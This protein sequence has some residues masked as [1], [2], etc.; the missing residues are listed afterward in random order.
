MKT[1]KAIIIIVLLSIISIIGIQTAT[2]QRT[3]AQ[4]INILSNVIAE[5]TAVTEGKEN[6]KLFVVNTIQKNLTA[7]IYILNNDSWIYI[8]RVNN[9]YEFCPIE[10]GDWS[11]NLNTEA[12]LY[13]I[14][15]TYK[16]IYEYGY[17]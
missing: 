4:P 12:D 17:Y 16:S 3:T 15:Q 11:Y 6:K 13:N 1:L 9:I 7:T 5:P 8:D 14:V 10:L 2:E